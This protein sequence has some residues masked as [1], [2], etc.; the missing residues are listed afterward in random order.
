VAWQ[1]IFFGGFFFGA[2]VVLLSSRMQQSEGLVTV[3]PPAR[4]PPVFTQPSCPW[5][6]VQ[7]NEDEVPDPDKVVEWLNSLEPGRSPEYSTVPN[8]SF[9]VN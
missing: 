7:G 9:T 6:V 2:S 4:V 5:L 3:T 8:I 1:S